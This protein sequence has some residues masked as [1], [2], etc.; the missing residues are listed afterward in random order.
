MSSSGYILE[1]H[2]LQ[3]EM[4]SPFPRFRT[5]GGINNIMDLL[6]LRA[7]VEY[8]LLDDVVQKLLT[9]Q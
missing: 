7:I 5:R 6:A 4:R 1:I 3:A 9:R 2:M 8:L